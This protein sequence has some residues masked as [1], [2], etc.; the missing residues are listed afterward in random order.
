MSLFAAAGAI[1][2]TLE[3]V[4]LDI[5]PRTAA[6]AERI[7]RVTA[8]T[9]DFGKAEP[10]ELNAGGAATATRRVNRDAFS[11]A[12]ANMAFEREMA[13]KVGNGLFR[14][15]WVS[16]PAST[17]ASDG[18]GP[19]YNARACQHCHLKDGR[20]HPPRSA[21]DDATS[22]LIRLSVP[23]ESHPYADAIPGYIPVAPEPVYGKQLQDRSVQGIPAEG[24]VAV[25]YEEIEVALSGGDRAVLRRPVWSIADPA[26]GPLSEDVMLSPRVAPAMIGLGLVEAIPAADI[27]ANA[28]PEDA[29]GDGISGR[30]NI[31][32]DELSGA[33]I[34][35]RFGWKAQTA[36][37]RQQ[38][39]DAFAGDIGISTPEMPKHWGDCTEAQKTCLALPNGVQERLGAVEAPPPV[40]DLVT[41]YSRNLAVPA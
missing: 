34:L 21:V 35:G 6:E 18:L 26:Y 33:V 15:L 31:V 37:I 8:P 32:R 19:L 13:F 7:A 17:E 16:S 30:P 9:Q 23:A 4:H 1:G 39:A 11:H 36:S 20:G 14:K 29:D 22:M 3:D 2:F 5:V 25:E 10:F 40:M 38:A 24:R 12:S 28:D 27:L 41:F